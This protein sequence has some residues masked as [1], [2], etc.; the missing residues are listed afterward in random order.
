MRKHGSSFDYLPNAT[1]ESLNTVGRI[2][3]LPN[4]PGIVEEGY[5]LCP[6]RAPTLRYMRVT[7]T[8][9]AIFKGLQGRQRFFGG[10]GL[11]NGL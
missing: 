1:V 2:Q 5:H 7:F 8:H 9:K 10:I 4:R 11:V 3:L 6:G